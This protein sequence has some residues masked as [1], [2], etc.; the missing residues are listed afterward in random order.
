MGNRI[1]IISN[2]RPSR[3]SRL[4]KRITR[5]IP[6]TEICGIIQRSLDNLP[7][8]QN[9]IASGRKDPLHLARWRSGSIVLMRSI[10]GTL[11]HTVLWCIHGC[12]K[13]INGREFGWKDLAEECCDSGC[14]FLLVDHLSEPRVLACVT[15][16]QP[17]LGIVVGEIA[18]GD[19]LLTIP[20]CGWIR[21]ERSGGQTERSDQDGIAIKI[22]LLARTPG[23]T[24]M[25]TQVTL[26]RQSYDSLSGQTLKAD[27]I[28]DDL[29]VQSVTHVLNASVVEAA[30]AV[31]EWLEETL[32]PYLKQLSTAPTSANESGRSVR[33]RPTWKLCLDTLL[34]CS[35]IIVA[36]NWYRRFRRQYPITILTHHLV[37]DRPHRMGISTELFWNQIRFLQRQYRIVSL[38]QAGELLKSGH[39]DAPTAVLTFDDGYSENFV[40]LRAVAEETGIP[41][42][43]FIATK[44]VELH[45][46]F[47]HDVE[48]GI[49]G[50]L[51]LTWQQIRYWN[52]GE[53]EFGSHTRTHC[54][55]GSNDRTILESEIV[56][57]KRDLEQRLGRPVK[58]FAFPFGQQENI[59]PEAVRLAQEC[60]CYFVSGFGGE[61]HG[62]SHKNNQ[63]LLRKG[64]YSNAW[65]LELD[66][67]SVFDLVDTIKQ[68]SYLGL[69]R[70]KSISARLSSVFSPSMTSTGPSPN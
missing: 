43:L 66:L 26:P 45:Q 42:T 60:Y 18:L 67:Q 30:H 65:E 70:F 50:A 29:T 4:A 41:V 19:E 7:S 10:L 36:R 59:S 52:S 48:N 6:G 12:P 8:A 13:G 39:V 64:F 16:Q 5:E 1:L 35:P 69:S 2:A 21:V 61:N 51:P 23:Q 57:S 56:D 22:E 14:P 31:N 46:E 27:L 28:A 32:S 49:R 37:S 63:H 47:Q 9:L 38:T 68:V 55:C 54:D 11:I 17:D 62:T 15:D 58:F 3:A 20:A 33:Y 34:L 53:V 25:M 40:N 24:V 44:P